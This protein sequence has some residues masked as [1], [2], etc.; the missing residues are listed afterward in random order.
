MRL[1]ARLVA[2]VCLTAAT[3]ALPVAPA[4]AA[5]CASTDGVTVVVDY[6]ELG[7]GVGQLCLE[8]GAG[9]YAATQFANAGFALTRV[10]QEPGF[11]C[12]VE[13]KPASDPCQ[14]TPPA[15]AYWGLWWSDG[16]S[17]SWT[18]ASTGVDSLK[19]PA[20][21]SVAL[22]WNGSATRSAPG[23]TPPANASS[24]PSPSPSP[25]PTKK[26]SPQ[27]G[28]GSPGSSG[29]ATQGSSGSASTSPSA[30][31]N[32][33]AAPP[34]SPAARDDGAD[35]AGDRPGAGPGAKADGRTGKADQRGRAGGK[36]G[37]RVEQ[38]RKRAARERDRVDRVDD[39][40]ASPTA[41]DAPDVS[42]AA[43]PTSE[44]LSSGGN[45]MPAWVA[46]SAIG[47]LFAAAA[48]TAVVRRRRG[49]A[50]T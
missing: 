16:K 5:A 33:S 4:Q 46:P 15:D 21:G 43:A 50:G 47:L 34:S 37:A 14:S 42:A 38:D 9:K 19:V 30:T 11:V 48:A 3:T 22:S 39:A 24:S 41:S 13:G 28:G 31:A 26:P 18:Y 49:A 8:D 40:S 6:H 20:G 45:A 25:K 12:R 29:G 27:P 1:V 35:G 17:G 23:A 44:P 36:P 32:G 10:Q 2:A 7:G